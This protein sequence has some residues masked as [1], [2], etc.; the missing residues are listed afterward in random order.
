VPFK[1][2]VHKYGLYKTKKPT[3]KHHDSWHKNN[4]KTI[5]FHLKDYGQVTNKSSKIVNY[6]NKFRD[7]L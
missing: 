3:R 2:Q 6:N 1:R 4:K 5:T 7:Y